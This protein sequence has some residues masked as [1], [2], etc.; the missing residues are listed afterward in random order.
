MVLF[1]PDSILKIYRLQPGD[2]RKRYYGMLRIDK[3][4]PGGALYLGIC[5]YNNG[6]YDGIQYIL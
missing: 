3:G 1:L 6:S 5:I 4:S 2:D